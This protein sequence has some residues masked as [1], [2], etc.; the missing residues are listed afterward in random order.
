MISRT[1]LIIAVSSALS[2]GALMADQAPAT[3]HRQGAR[4]GFLDRMSTALSL[5][6]Q[7]KQDAKAIFKSERESVK[8]V[9]QELFA[10]RKA[11][12][13]AI[14]AGKP[15]T[16]VQQLATKEGAALGNLAAVR[17]EAFA[18]FYAELTPAQQ[19]KVAGLHREWRAKHRNSRQS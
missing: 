8:P 17:A 13:E 19:Q 4:E 15:A 1:A 12:R 10:E 2:A 18:K 14:E 16:E 9:R 6:D 11:V 7:Q 3:R 5:T